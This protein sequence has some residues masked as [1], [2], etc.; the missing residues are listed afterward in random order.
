MNELLVVSDGTEARLGT[1]T[2]GRE[3]FMPWR[4][5]SGDGLAEFLA[6]FEGQGSVLIV[7]TGELDVGERHG[8]LHQRHVD[9][10]AAPVARAAA[11]RWRAADRAGYGR[12]PAPRHGDSMVG[13]PERLSSRVTSRKLVSQCTILINC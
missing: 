8:I 5:V 3:W 7:R 11:M 1:L 4:T 13:S 6:P 12:Y 10:T 2:A 9:R